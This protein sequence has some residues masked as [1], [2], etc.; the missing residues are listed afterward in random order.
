MLSHLPEFIANHTALVLMFLAVAGALAWNVFGGMQGLEQIEPM[1][2]VQLINHEDAIVIDVR[3]S[4]EFAQG[5][6][7]DSRHIPL[8]SFSNQL[9][10]LQNH[11][12]TPIILS[13]QSGHRSSQACRILKQNGFEKVYNMRGGMMA[14]QN[15]S[16][17]VQK[18]TAKGKKSKS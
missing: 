2:A 16:L 3:E 13:C 6:I 15:A 4:G 8:G 17:P 1:S 10:T 5:H 7:L 18:N 9:G 14:W 12:N 11:K